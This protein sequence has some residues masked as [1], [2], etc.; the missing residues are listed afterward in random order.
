M[1]IEL[2]ETTSEDDTIIKSLETKGSGMHHIAYAVEDGMTEALQQCEDAGIRLIDKS[3]CKGVE[4]LQILF[5]SK[6]F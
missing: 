3:P 6:K 4:G 1:K 2:F 5:A